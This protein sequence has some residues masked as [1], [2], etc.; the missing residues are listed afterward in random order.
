MGIGE[1]SMHTPA[2]TLLLDIQLIQATAIIIDMKNLNH[3]GD[4]INDRADK[5]VK[6]IFPS[7]FLE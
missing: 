6:V 2:R 7:T 4:G 3:D 1:Q 5:L